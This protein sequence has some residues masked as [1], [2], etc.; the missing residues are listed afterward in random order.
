MVFVVEDVLV[1]LGSQVVTTP[2]LYVEYPIV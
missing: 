1:F 2:T